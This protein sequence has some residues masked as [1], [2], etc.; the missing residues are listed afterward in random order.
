MLKCRLRRRRGVTELVATVLLVAATLVAGFAVWGWVNGETG[1]TEGQYGQSVGQGVNALQEAFTV[2]NV[3]FSST[4]VTLW[5]YD[6][7]QIALQP[8]SVFVYNSTR[9]L[10]ALF[11][12]TKVVDLDHPGTCD[13]AVTSQ[14]ESSTLYNPLTGS[15]P[16]N[17]IDIQPQ[18]LQSLTLGFPSQCSSLKFV[19]GASYTFAV[20]GRYGNTVTYYQAMQA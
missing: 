2:A 6:K 9:S 5:F 13:V 3:N 16:G 10:Y 20:Q 12:A 18:G 15:Q 7:G 14:Y 4:H 1:V 8:V 17:V 19:A 11:N